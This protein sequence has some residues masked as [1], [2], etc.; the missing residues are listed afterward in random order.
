MVAGSTQRVDAGGDCQHSQVAKVAL[1][2]LAA[3]LADIMR[4][5]KRLLKE[6]VRIVHLSKILRT[7]FMLDVC[8]STDVFFDSLE[9]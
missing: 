7:F 5:V 6:S 8:L 3:T 4:A 1:I 2:A 9:V